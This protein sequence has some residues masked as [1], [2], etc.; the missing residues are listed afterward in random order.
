MKR[1]YVYVTM[2]EVLFLLTDPSAVYLIITSRVG[3]TRY[4]ITEAYPELI[5]YSRY[6]RITSSD[7][8]SVTEQIYFSNSVANSMSRININGTLQE[9]VRLK[10]VSMCFI[11]YQQDEGCT[12]RLSHVTPILALLWLLVLLS[13]Y[14]RPTS[15]S[16]CFL[17]LCLHSD[18]F[19]ILFS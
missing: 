19:I 3:I 8:D 9:T 11:S 18:T 1:A 7:F 5:H 4:S 14:L 2:E 12:G 6:Q 16:F 10:V 13:S 15:M 17:W